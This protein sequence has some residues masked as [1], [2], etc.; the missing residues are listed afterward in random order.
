VARPVRVLLVSSHPIQYGAPVWRRY[1]ADPRLEVTVAFCSL[2]GAESGI[3]PDLGVEVAWDVPLLDGYRWVHPPNWAP[4]SGLERF[5]G[6]VNPGLWPLIRRGGFDVVVCSGWRAAS[7]WIAA[8]AAKASRASLVFWLDAHTLTP[9]NGRAW[10]VPLKRALIPLFF[11]I[12]DAGFGPSSRTIVLLRSLGLDDERIF[13]IHYVVDN[14]FF[15]RA[16]EGVDRTAVRARWVVPPEAPI[17]LFVGKL[18]PWKRPLDLLEAAARVPGLHVVFAGD[19]SLR[20][21][22]EFRAARPDLVGRVCFLGFTNQSALPEVYAGS[23]VLVLPSEYESFGLVVNEAFAVG[24]PAV[25]T[26]ACGAAG[27]LVRDGE[28]GYVVD[29]GDIE[30]LA[31]RLETLARD[32]DLKHAL[33]TAARAR[34]ARW[35][36]EQNAEAFAAACLKLA[37]KACR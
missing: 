36:P 4:R 11:R 28:T 5:W 17:A 15:A 7:F 30:A 9:R 26:R 31:G 16:A 35:G 19:G 23:D 27:D 13:L 25:V 29:V 34:V 2:Q 8:L 1:A 20:P 18:V 10:K 12:A 3:D 14:E 22:L 33:G 21:A 37:R 24:R 32:R 6:L